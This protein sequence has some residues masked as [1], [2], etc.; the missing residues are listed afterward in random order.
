[1]CL[2]FFIHTPGGTLCSL[3]MHDN[4]ATQ[5]PEPPVRTFAAAGGRGSG[6]CW[7]PELRPSCLRGWVVLLWFGAVWF[8]ALR[9]GFRISGTAGVRGMP[10]DPALH[11]PQFCHGSTGR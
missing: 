7:A 5:R 3:L 4:T 9:F 1:M 6:A 11:A 8:G 10:R 2:A